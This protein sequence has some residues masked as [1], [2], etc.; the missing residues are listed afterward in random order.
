MDKVFNNKTK[1][2]GLPIDSLPSIIDKARLVNEVDNARTGRYL[3]FGSPELNAATLGLEHHTFFIPAPPNLGKCLDGKTLI[4]I[5]GSLPIELEKLTSTDIVSLDINTLKMIETK[6]SAAISNG[7]KPCWKIRTSLGHEI[8]ATSNHPFFTIEGWKELNQL[9]I[10]SKVAVANS[11][12]FF[13]TINISK[14]ECRILGL[15]LGDGSILSSNPTFTSADPILANILIEDITTLLGK[16]NIGLHVKTESQITTSF[17]FSGQEG[18]KRTTTTQNNIAE[19]LGISSPAVSMC[20]NSSPKISKTLTRKVKTK[21]KELGYTNTGTGLPKCE[22]IKFLES[23]NMR[24]KTAGFKTVPDIIFNTT[25]ENIA[26]F[27]S[28][29]FACDGSAYVQSNKDISGITYTSKSERLIRD[30]QHL[31]LRFEIVSTIRKRSVLCSN[32]KRCLAWQLHILDRENVLRF[33][34]EIGILQKEKQLQ[35]VIDTKE[36]RQRSKNSIVNHIPKE[37]APYVC[38]LTGNKVLP[39]KLSTIR[40]SMR[41]GTRSI[42]RDR[43]LE[44]GEYL[45]DSYLQNLGQSSVVWDKIVEIEFVGDREVYDIEVPETHNF[46]ANNFIVHNSS[47]MLNLYHNLILNNKDVVVLDLSYDDAFD[48]RFRNA[49]ARLARIPINWVKYPNMDNIPKEAKKARYDAMKEWVAKYTKQLIIVDQTELDGQAKYLSNLEKLI[50]YYKDLHTDK[51]LVVCIDGLHDIFP[52]NHPFG[53]NASETQMQSWVSSRLKDLAEQAQVT[54]IATAHVA[55]LSPRRGG[56][57]FSIK[58]S[59]KTG[60]DAHLVGTVFSDYKLN[61]GNAEVWHDATLPHIPDQTV[62]LPVLELDITKSKVSEYSNI[63]FFR[64][65]PSYCLLEEASSKWQEHWREVVYGSRKDK[66]K[67]ANP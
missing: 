64:H 36:N 60:Y 37:I 63:I 30:I 45:D 56:D 41:N 31:L 57:A 58:G 5:P 59:G 12:P 25:K 10:G 20:L 51:K 21:A 14:E 67:S 55:K 38:K 23:H 11:T 66:T 2:E 47:L 7:I 40:T 1:W 9:S 46:I 16:H 29:L 43:L 28:S 50:W 4:T 65:Y 18:Y 49:I 34:K 42:H 15:M 17:R 35:N 52:D 19:V 33:A 53:H 54:I 8:I 62:R 39:D 32:G 3:D 24:G 61:R 48:S 44:I 26:E 27:L 6:S 22:L 13:G